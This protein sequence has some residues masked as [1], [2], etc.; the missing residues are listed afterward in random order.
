MPGPSQKSYMCM[1]L[2]LAPFVTDWG[3]IEDVMSLLLTSQQMFTGQHTLKVANADNRFSS[4][5]PAS[6]FYGRNLQLLPVALSMGNV[7]LYQGFLRDPSVDH[8]SR[9]VSILSE[10]A[11]TIAANYFVNL[12]TTGNPAAI[13]SSI[14]LNAGLQNYIDPISFAAAQG[15]FAAAGATISVNYV[16]TGAVNIADGISGTTALSAIQAICD[17]CSMDCFVQSGLI[18]LY[19]YQ[20]Y[21]GNLSAIK[22]QITPDQVYSFGELSTA[23]QSLYNSVNVGY[24]TDSNL[25]LKNQSSILANSTVPGGRTSEVNQQF[26]GVIGNTLMVPNLV[27]ANYFGA[28]F[29][30]RASV[31]KR[32]GTLTAGP[33]LLQA[34][35][36]DRCTI[37]A[38][39]WCSAPIAFE[40]I[41]TNLDLKSESISLTVAT[42]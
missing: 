8:G 30:A 5:N 7:L 36:G 15:G 32:Q 12:T 40:I 10:N 24:G 17:L 16:T 11:F 29:L 4:G 42:I 22:W 39:N 41:Q 1:G 33:A 35:I 38:P 19:P 37:T 26:D 20:P 9:I 2:E 6:I 34:K 18:R 23:Y 14:L 3:N 21:Q 28:Q 31:I 13:V 25:Y 27:S